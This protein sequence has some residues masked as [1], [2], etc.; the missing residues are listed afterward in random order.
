[1]SQQTMRWGG[2]ERLLLSTTLVAHCNLTFATNPYIIREVHGE[3]NLY[4][5]ASLTVPQTETSV[6]SSGEESS[7]SQLT[8]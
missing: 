8:A 3:K 2:S 7:I 6:S 4:T 1:M 5:D